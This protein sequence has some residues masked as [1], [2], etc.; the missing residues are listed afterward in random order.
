M[1][2]RHQGITDKSQSGHCA[3]TSK[4]ANVKID[5]FTMGNN[6]TCTYRL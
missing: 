6:I 4:S 2:A 3:H 1:K 5:T